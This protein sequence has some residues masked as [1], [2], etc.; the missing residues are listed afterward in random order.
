[1]C[2]PESGRK[3]ANCEKEDLWEKM[4]KICE[5]VNHLQK[6]KEH[7]LN[8]HLVSFP[9]HIGTHLSHAGRGVNVEVHLLS[10]LQQGNVIIFV[11]FFTVMVTMDVE[12]RHID[13]LLWQYSLPC[14]CSVVIA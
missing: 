10:Q 7:N 11:I 3:R 6:N 5:N 8:K 1:M 4:G 14:D 9:W 12:S 13:C 2:P